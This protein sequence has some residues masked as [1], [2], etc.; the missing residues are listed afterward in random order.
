M[1]TLLDMTLLVLWS[2]QNTVIPR[3]HLLQRYIRVD[4]NGTVTRMGSNQMSYFPLVTGRLVLVR[5]SGYALRRFTTIAVRYGIVRR[6]FPSSSAKSAPETQLLD[7][8]THQARLMPA[9][10]A[11]FAFH[12]A[13][14]AA[15]AECAVIGADLRAGRASARLKPMHAL[16]AGLKALTTG[17][18]SELIEPIRLL[19][20][21]HGFSAL[22]GMSQHIADFGV[23]P[24][25]EGQSVHS[26]EHSCTAHRQLAGRRLPLCPCVRCVDR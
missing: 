22:S 12:F 6:Q 5:A 13:G 1:R 18:T 9:L 16:S 23:L 11:A 7:Y 10:A 26:T 3:D 2:V 4:R 14:A 24:T 19:C 20:G 8:P 15:T 21:G 25:F 17:L